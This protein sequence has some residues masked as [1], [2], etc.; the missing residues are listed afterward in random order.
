MNITYEEH[1]YKVFPFSTDD[2]RMRACI[3]VTKKGIT[4][5]IT[6]TNATMGM[7][8]LYATGLVAALM[9]RQSF[10][11]IQRCRTIAEKYDYVITHYYNEEPKQRP[12]VDDGFLHVTDAHGT[13]S[14]F[15]VEHDDRAV[16]DE[17]VETI[18]TA[19]GLQRYIA[20]LLT[21]DPE[22]E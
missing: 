12:Y 13:R 17:R 4:S 8:R 9:I 19:L 1:V 6:L 3:E 7:T 21:E 20:R 5:D 2:P 22:S 18:L 14:V 16:Q 10:T 11:F 15:R